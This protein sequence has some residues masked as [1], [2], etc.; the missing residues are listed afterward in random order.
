MKFL[1]V[2]TNYIS[3]FHSI[4]FVLLNLVSLTLHATLTGSIYFGGSFA[5][6]K[7][8]KFSLS[9]GFLIFYI[10]FTNNKDFFPE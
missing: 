7:D 6:H 5:V 3:G 10:H 4:E 1:K 2:Y 9:C 8:F